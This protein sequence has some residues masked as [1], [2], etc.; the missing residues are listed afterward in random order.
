MDVNNPPGCPLVHVCVVAYNHVKY[1]R[2]CL[3]GVLA[4]K[5]RFAYVVLV[6]DD[7]STDGTADIVREYAVRHPGKVKPILQQTNQFSQGKTVASLVFPPCR[8]SEYIA[9]CEGDDYWT[10]ELKLQKQVDLMA[11]HPDVGMSFHPVFLVRGD[12]PRSSC[13]VSD[14]F[15]E[16]TVVPLERLIIG[17]GAYCP[18]PSL[19]FRSKYA[20]DIMA[21]AS[22]M[23]GDY[24][25]Q[26]V[27]GQHGALYIN[28]PMAVYR[29]MVPG[30]WSSRVE[31]DMKLKEHHYLKAIEG[32]KVLD[33]YFKERCHAA[34]AQVKARHYYTIAL[35][36]LRRGD[37][38]A[39]A[40]SAWRCEFR[41]KLSVLRFALKLLR[42]G[43]IWRGK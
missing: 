39:A 35:S 42:T 9:V 6:H 8:G 11:L 18:S 16:N 34:V 4:Q 25:V 3:D 28:E 23:S 33:D 22:H 24:A 29:H 40:R 7:C 27:S 2:A 17:G 21:C 14:W 12:E 36:A 13:V 20:D 19:V 31:A 37:V 1:I 15:K 38:V 10:D 26:V 43:A 30:S 32:M 41:Q 5:T